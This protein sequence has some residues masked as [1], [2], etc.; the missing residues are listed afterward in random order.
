M[1]RN[2]FKSIQN[3]FMNTNKKKYSKQYSKNKF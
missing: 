3:T 2:T 1:E